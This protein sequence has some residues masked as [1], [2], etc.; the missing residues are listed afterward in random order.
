MDAV[1]ELDAERQSVADEETLEQPDAVYDAECVAESDAKDAEPVAVVESEKVGDGVPLTLKDGDTLAVG[2]PVCE[3]LVVKEGVVV[4]HVDCVMDGVAD[5]DAVAQP[6][7]ETHEDTDA[8]YVGDGEYVADTHAEVV[9]ERQSVDDEDCVELIVF[10]GLAEKDALSV[11][12]T[13]F[14]TDR[15]RESVTDEVAERESDGVPD[16]DRVTDGDAEKET[17]G[18]GLPELDS[19]GE[20]DALVEIECVSEIVPVIVADSVS[21]VV[22]VA[23]LVAVGVTDGQLDAQ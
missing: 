18:V 23:V 13:E 12:D 10:V 6:D 9:A 22:A 14:V 21:D 8:E 4:P 15:V 19:V 16:T 7:A 20:W 2:L 1:G 11:D 5:C 3:V 17:V